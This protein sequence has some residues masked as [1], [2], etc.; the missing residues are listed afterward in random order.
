[1][2]VGD[3]NIRP[4]APLIRTSTSLSRKGYGNFVS[5]EDRFATNQ[6][7][8][9]STLSH[10]RGL[11]GPGSYDPVSPRG[12]S[13][14]RQVTERTDFRIPPSVAAFN[15]SSYVDPAPPQYH[16]PGPGAYPHEHPPQPHYRRVATH[17]P[18]RDAAVSPR[19]GDKN[20]LTSVARSLRAPLQ[21][22]ALAFNAMA[23]R[24]LGPART[25]TSV[26]SEEVMPLP[27]SV[28]EGTGAR[29]VFRST[30]ARQ[31]F[32]DKS[33]APGPAT[34][35]SEENDFP[36]LK[37]VKEY[38]KQGLPLSEALR[39]SQKDAYVNTSRNHGNLSKNPYI[40][41]SVFQKTVPPLQ[42]VPEDFPG[43]G[44]Y[45]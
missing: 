11:P 8:I 39:T 3:Y 15:S 36:R 35:N 21:E 12:G 14:R 24:F 29:S 7:F 19:A 16:T 44:S 22:N 27:S 18:V 34:Y 33:I 25:S 42:P 1:M 6:A 4:E 38:I 9:G 32:P 10:T 17:S 2:G 40:P 5:K 20:S 31:A 37:P 45:L 30:T 43:P 23:P 41:S 13:P 28:A 26:H